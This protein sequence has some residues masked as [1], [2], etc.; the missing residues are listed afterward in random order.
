M[1][2]S[3][4]ILTAALAGFTLASPATAQA[5]TMEERVAELESRVSELETVVADLELAVNEG[6]PC[7]TGAMAL[8]RR[9]GTRVLLLTGRKTQS[10]VYVAMIDRSCVAGVRDTFAW[11]G[12]KNP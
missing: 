3:L 8:S 7:V 9:R 12:Y 1:G 2:R 4:V 11:P 5:P 10:K 6:D